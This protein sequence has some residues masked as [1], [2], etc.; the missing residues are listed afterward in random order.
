LKLFIKSFPE[1][2]LRGKQ[3]PKGEGMLA[4]VMTKPRRK[5]YP[6]ASPENDDPR[7]RTR[8]SMASSGFEVN[9]CTREKGQGHC[10]ESIRDRYKRK[11]VSKL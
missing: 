4:T 2:L 1:P 7:S 10:N 6:S 5:A 3:C 9:A 8:K 11:L